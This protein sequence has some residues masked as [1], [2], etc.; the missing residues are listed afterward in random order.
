[1]YAQAGEADASAA[2]MAA[3]ATTIPS[4]MSRWRRRVIDFL[5]YDRK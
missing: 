3:G 2:T 4:R 1:M 5:G